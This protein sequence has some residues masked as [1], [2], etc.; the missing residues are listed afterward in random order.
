MCI[1]KS[2]WD[3]VCRRHPFNDSNASINDFICTYAPAP[4]PWAWVFFVLD[5]KFLGK[6]NSWIATHT[7]RM[8]KCYAININNSTWLLYLHVYSRVQ[9][10]AHKPHLKVQVLP[11][12][13]SNSSGFIA[14]LV[15]ALHRCHKVTGSNPVE[16]LNI[17]FRL[18]NHYCEGHSSV[19]LFVCFCFPFS[20]SPF[21]DV[22]CWCR[23]RVL[24]MQSA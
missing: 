18:L 17:F 16:V 2:C 13:A 7:L 20:N 24:H 23:V 1:G 9:L 15:R 10:L 19:D 21:Q 8:P 3:S 6:L 12:T 4:L 11:K 22:K 5:G 14:Q